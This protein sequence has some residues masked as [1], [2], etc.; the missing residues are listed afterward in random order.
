LSS[1]TR[2]VEEAGRL[3]SRTAL[4]RL[5]GEEAATEPGFMQ[6]LADAL[7]K[8]PR[9][10][11]QQ[12]L[13]Y[14]EQADELDALMEAKPKTPPPPKPPAP[15]LGPPTVTCGSM[16]RAKEQAEANSHL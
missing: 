1:V 3:G 5:L 15:I 12:P 8:C 14:L 9:Y 11:Q 16:A 7:L 13:P 4:Q 10:Y 2:V 6:D